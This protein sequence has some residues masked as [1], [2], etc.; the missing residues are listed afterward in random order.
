MAS[1]MDN[2][3][4]S[5]DSKQFAGEFMCLPWPDGCHTMFALDENGK[6]PDFISEVI[7]HNLASKNNNLQ[8]D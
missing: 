1:K 2:T 5:K 8:Q 3:V 6:L 4:M 7:E